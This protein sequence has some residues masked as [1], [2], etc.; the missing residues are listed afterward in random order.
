MPI[1]GESLEEPSE[2]ENKLY[3]IVKT[4]DFLKIMTNH[5]YIYLYIYIY[6]GVS[7]TQ[8]RTA[9]AGGEKVRKKSRLGWDLASTGTSQQIRS[10]TEPSRAKP[11]RANPGRSELIRSR[12]G[13]AQPSRA[14]PPSFP[15]F[16]PRRSFGSFFCKN[17]NFYNELCSFVRP[18]AGSHCGTFLALGGIGGRAELSQTDPSRAGPGRAEPR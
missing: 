7:E 17:V 14:D 13:Q 11:S 10:R 9:V 2:A 8:A 1:S 3:V 6:M 4:R 12:P 15:N 16:F 5:I 18:V